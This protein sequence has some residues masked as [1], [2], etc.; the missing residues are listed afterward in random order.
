[1]C[2]ELLVGALF[3]EAAVVEHEDEIGLS[4]GGEPVGDDEAGAM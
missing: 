2:D 1:M 3:D 4:N